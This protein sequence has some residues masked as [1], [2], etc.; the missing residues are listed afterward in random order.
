MIRLRLSNIVV[1]C[2]LFCLLLQS[3]T[4]QNSKVGSDTVLFFNMHKLQIRSIS[5]DEYKKAAK[6]EKLNIDTTL[7][8]KKQGELVLS[9]AGNK[10]MIL[11]DSLSN[12]DNTEQITYNYWGHFNEVGFY[13]IKVQYYESG[14]Y[15]LI[16]DKTGI[17]TQV[18]GEPKLSPDKKHIVSASNGIEYDILP[19]GIQMWLI[20]KDALKL[21]WE[22]KQKQ[23][24]P[25][26][27]IW[28]NQNCFYFT[29]HIPDFLSK[30]KKEENQYAEI[31]V[32]KN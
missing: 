22:Y 25:D 19:N 12:S 1:L 4:A 15:L 24:G 13:I 17:K 26:G 2:D 16:N 9:L 29:K 10:M 18:W 5:E 6:A 8:K 27:I 31:S 20:Q 14:E 3:C 11:R 7:V 30:N 28:I 32:K 23:W 21:E